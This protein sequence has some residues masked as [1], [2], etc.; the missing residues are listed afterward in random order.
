MCCIMTNDPKAKLGDALKNL[1]KLGVKLHPALQIA[2]DKLYGYTS[3]EGGIR[4]CLLEQ[5]TIY[6][7]DA[8]FMLVSCSAFVNLLKARSIKTGDFS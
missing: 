3:N 1:E 8:K 6:F 7:E 5:S 2:F 4:H